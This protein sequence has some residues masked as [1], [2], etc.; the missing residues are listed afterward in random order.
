MVPGALPAGD[1]LDLA[2]VLATR[3]VRLE[4]MVD[5][6]NRLGVSVRPDWPSVRVE[7]PAGGRVIPAAAADLYV[8]NSGDGTSPPTLFAFDATGVTNCSG[9]PR[10]TRV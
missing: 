1:L 2:T 8:A 6:L 7:R 3:P 5:G 9:S 10:N 4:A